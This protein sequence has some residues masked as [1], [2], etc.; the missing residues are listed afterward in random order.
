MHKTRIE[1]IVTKPVSVQ[2][3]PATPELH[4]ALGGKQAEPGSSAGSEA[5]PKLVR[6]GAKV[7]PKGN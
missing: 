3:D 4:R 1:E 5:K 6:E 2:H 7:L